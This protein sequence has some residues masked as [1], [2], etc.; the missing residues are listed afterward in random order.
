MMNRVELHRRAVK[1]LRSEFVRHGFEVDTTKPETA[2]QT[3]VVHNLAK[4]RV[5]VK[6]SR[7]FNYNYI[8]KAHMNPHKSLI[9]GFVHFVTGE[10]PHLYLIRSTEW[11]A[12]GNLLKS[13]NYRGL[14]SHPEYGLQLSRKNIGLLQ[15]YSFNR[16]VSTL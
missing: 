4:Y 14:A 1:L 3:F 11:L 15:Q 16:I 8:L 9:I 5:K 7:D 10:C 6:S 13:R 2:S 12:P